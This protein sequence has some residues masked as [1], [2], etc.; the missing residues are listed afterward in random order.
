MEAADANPPNSD[1]AR[2][3][4]ACVVS[5]GIHLLALWLGHPAWPAPWRE[6]LPRGV[7]T[8]R[9]A[10][11]SPPPTAKAAFPSAAPASPAASPGR[12]DGNGI[13]VR[14]ARLL[15]PPDLG[16]LEEIPIARSG[17]ATFRLYVT[18]AGTVEK[19]ELRRTDPAPTELISALTRQFRQARLSPAETSDAA[20]ASTLDIVIRFAPAVE[21]GLPPAS[22]PPSS[23]P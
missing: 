22:D 11:G 15:S 5:L 17:S 21:L 6:V 12:T 14:R 8:V 23:G 13:P 7:V 1:S 2:M 9:I 18:A 16:A 20:V 3:A 10:S 19:V 4:K